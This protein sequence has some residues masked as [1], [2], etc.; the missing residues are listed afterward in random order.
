MPV[1]SPSYFPPNRANGTIVGITAGETTTGSRNFLAG[2][3]AGAYLTQSDVIAIGDSALSA[4]TSSA[5]LTDAGVGGA[6]VIG[7]NAAASWYDTSNSTYASVIV[8]TNASSA[9]NSGGQNVIIGGSAAA[10]YNGKVSGIGFAPL[11]N[12]VV[13]G[14]NTF[15]TA[16]GGNAGIGPAASNDSVIIG[17]A[18]AGGSVASNPA[19]TVNQTII[20]G[21]L[22]ATVFGQSL[23]NQ[24]HSISECIVIG[25][26]ALSGLTNGGGQLNSVLIGNNVASGFSGGNNNSGSVLIGSGANAANN[27]SG[28]TGVGYSVNCQAGNSVAVGY[29]AQA[30][31]TATQSF[32]VA[33]GYK[34]G[35]GGTEGI[36]SELLIERHDDSANLANACLYGNFDSGNVIL[37]QSRH[38]VNRDFGGT[39]STNILKLLAG[40]VGNS[41][42]VGGGYFY[43]TGANN[44]VHWVGSDGTDTNLVAGASGALAY[45]YNA[46]A[47]GFAITVGNDIAQLVLE[48]AGTL[49]SGTVTLP[50]APEDGDTV[51]I[52]STQAITAL[53]I[54]PN[55]GQT[56]ADAPTSFAIGG[57][58]RF[59]YRATNTTWYRIGN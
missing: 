29:N 28:S 43:L 50:A 15:G 55:A 1:S 10:K 59:L 42:P 39:G 3:G 16:L 54:S 53:T 32:C 17:F 25:Y 38:T 23:S 36:N 47:T 13:I 31:T 4:G 14:A 41:N 21:S 52:S 33:I 7:S 56:V 48:P 37:G 57:S 40:T 30:G 18:A 27:S 9:L 44:D 35:V 46:P 12:M 5:P 20:L 6:T 49:A 51:G 2:K 45:T 58:V 19:I 8:G 34:A 24:I 26:N 11:K 22:A